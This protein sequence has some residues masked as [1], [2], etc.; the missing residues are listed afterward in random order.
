MKVEVDRSISNL[1]RPQAEIGWELHSMWL[2]LAFGTPAIDALF[3]VTF[4][5]QLSDRGLARLMNLQTRVATFTARFR[6]TF[7]GKKP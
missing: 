5:H 4:S 3:E 7:A 6:H 2:S 1:P